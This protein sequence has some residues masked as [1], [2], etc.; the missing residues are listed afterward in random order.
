MLGTCHSILA[1][2][3]ILAT[4][5]SATF[6]GTVEGSATYRERIA[7][8]PDATLFVE[9]QDVSMADAPALTLSAQR[10][11]IGGVPVGFELTYDDTLIQDNHSYVV[12]ASITQ[13]QNLLFTTDT[14]YPV[15]TNGA[16]NSADLILV[17]AQQ[18]AVL[19]NTDWTAVLLDGAPIETDR[20]PELS[21]VSGGAFSGSGGCNRFSGTAEIS[22]NRIEFPENMAAT[23]M[24]CPSPLDEVERQFFK[25]LQ[26]VT[27]YAAQGNALALLDANGEPVVEFSRKQ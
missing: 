23:L 13:G 5:A 6:A 19:E 3:A 25:G 21:F 12:R 24:A 8:P 22:G 11:A 17:Q 15:L 10:Y 18:D 7:V 9:L 2:V 27:T 16:A 20:R 1:S 14:A 4:L 26:R